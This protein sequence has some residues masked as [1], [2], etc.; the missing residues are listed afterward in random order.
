MAAA[1]QFVLP[2]KAHQ[3][4]C[5][6]WFTRSEAGGTAT[7]TE[8]TLP[9]CRIH[10]RLHDAAAAADGGFP[11]AAHLSSSSSWHPAAAPGVAAGHPAAA[12]G[13]RRSAAA[14]REASPREA[15]AAPPAS[16]PPT[17]ALRGPNCGPAA[18][19][20]CLVQPPRPFRRTLVCTRLQRGHGASGV[21]SGAAQPGA[22]AAGPIA[23][24]LYS[25]HP[26]HPSSGRASAT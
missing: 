12:R 7:V 9:P 15:A 25:D 22:I 18:R 1:R 26:A 6:C 20:S 3:P 21:V 5:R 13:G 10:Q 8:A 17:A 2:G 23:S 11:R 16:L 24:A 19:T 14:W 4:H